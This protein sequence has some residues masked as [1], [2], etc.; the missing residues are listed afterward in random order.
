METSLKFG[1]LHTVYTAKEEFVEH[2]QIVVVDNEET[3]QVITESN[4]IP[5]VCSD[6]KCSRAVEHED[7]CFIDTKSEDGDVYCD[8]C[9]KCLRYARKMESRRRE[10][11]SN[12]HT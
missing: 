10:I 2:E 11:V 8:S 9:G 7:P 1:M 12:N 5:V 6:E 3:I 4:R